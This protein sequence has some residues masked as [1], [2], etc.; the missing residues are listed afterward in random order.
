MTSNTF[1]TSSQPKVLQL[2]G[3]GSANGT[4]ILRV[5]STG[6][7]GING[8]NTTMSSAT[9][10]KVLK[11]AN[12]KQF[13]IPSGQIVFIALPKKGEELEEEEGQQAAT[14]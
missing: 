5:N 7:G 6:G 10:A 14:A 9:T 1:T 11:L 4:K 13:S 8:A 12:G 2:S 3:T